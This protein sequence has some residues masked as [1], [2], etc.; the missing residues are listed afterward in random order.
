MWVDAITTFDK[1]VKEETP[2]DKL[3]VISRTIN[4]IREIFGIVS[5]SSGKNIG[6]V[7]DEYPVLLYV[8]SKSLS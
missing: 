6:G 5:I 4:I 3:M 1:L 2:L 7:D 8:I